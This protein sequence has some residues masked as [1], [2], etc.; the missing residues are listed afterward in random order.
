MR[1]LNQ[2]ESGKL[3]EIKFTDPSEG[4]LYF[5]L[6]DGASFDES[7]LGIC[8]KLEVIT[9]HERN[10]DHNINPNKVKNSLIYW[11]NKYDSGSNPDF[12][13]VSEEKLFYDGNGGNRISVGVV[14]VQGVKE[15]NK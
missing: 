1:Y 2:E 15:I 7:Q 11:I 13:V 10:L 5:R 12:V 9:A 14:A 3:V 4:D 8:G 6:K